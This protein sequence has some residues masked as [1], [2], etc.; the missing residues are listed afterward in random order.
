MGPGIEEATGHPAA[1]EAESLGRDT[2][3]AESR[4]RGRP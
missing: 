3:E 4:G 1:H 2:H